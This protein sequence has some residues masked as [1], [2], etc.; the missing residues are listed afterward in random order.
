MKAQGLV[1][2]PDSS[3]AP[4]PRAQPKKKFKKLSK[5]D[6]MLMEEKKA[7]ERLQKEQVCAKCSERT[8]VS[9]PEFINKPAIGAGHLR[10]A[11]AQS[12]SS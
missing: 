10:M 1:P 3:A 2:T 9:E 7:Q 8:D 4:P 5:R 12:I 6:R 11:L